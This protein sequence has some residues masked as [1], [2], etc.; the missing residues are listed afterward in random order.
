MSRR[1]VVTYRNQLGVPHAF[2]QVQDGDTLGLV[3]AVQP[4]PDR[5]DIL[6]PDQVT[7]LGL[8]TARE[9]RANTCESCV[10]EWARPKG[11]SLKKVRKVVYTYNVDSIMPSDALLLRLCDEGRNALHVLALCCRFGLLLGF[12]LLCLLGT[13]RAGLLLLC[14]A[15]PLLAGRAKIDE[16]VCP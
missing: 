2:H 9:Q 3:A 13:L 6:G 7:E 5:H 14:L 1:V 8:H 10:R 16:E 11:E 15:L 4:A 12:A